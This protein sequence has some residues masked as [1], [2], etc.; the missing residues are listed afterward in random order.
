MKF[1]IYW[2]GK[3]KSQ[4]WVHSYFEFLERDKKE[5][6]FLVKNFHIVFYLKYKKNQFNDSHLINEIHSTEI[7]SLSQVDHRGIG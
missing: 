2:L 6:L 1:V 3:N 4:R 7:D 5:I